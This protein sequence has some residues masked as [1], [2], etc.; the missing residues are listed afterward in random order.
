MQSDPAGTCPEKDRF[1]IERGQQAGGRHDRARECQ[2]GSHGSECGTC[3]CHGVAYGH[4]RGTTYGCSRVDQSQLHAGGLRVCQ[5][6]AGSLPIGR[7]CS[8]KWERKARGP[9][10][11]AEALDYRYRDDDSIRPPRAPRLIGVGVRV[12][13]RA[14]NEPSFARIARTIPPPCARCPMTAMIFLS[15]VMLVYGYGVIPSVAMNREGFVAQ[16]PNSPT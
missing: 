1:S 11:P 10:T 6:R 3:T 16:E 5:L 13:A 14:A 12:M 15:P 9:G 2:I 7:K 8:Q 4:P